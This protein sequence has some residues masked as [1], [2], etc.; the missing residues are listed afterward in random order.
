MSYT[1]RSHHI[2]VVDD[3]RDL[4]DSVTEALEDAGYA[5]TAAHDGAQALAYLRSVSERPDLILLDLQ[6]PHVNG[7]EFR[8]EQLR[9][10]EYAAIPVAVITADA[11]A[12]HRMASLKL[13]AFLRKPLTI[14]ALLEVTARVL[15]TP[16]CLRGGEGTS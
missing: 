13:A 6:M 10:P 11:S 9:S 14:P 5:V 16:R 8:E 15:G 3:D 7:I 2:L 1:R 4:R 12:N